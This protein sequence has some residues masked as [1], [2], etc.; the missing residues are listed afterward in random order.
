MLLNDSCWFPL[1][2]SKDWLTLAET[3]GLDYFGAASNYGIDAPEI[4]RF[5]RA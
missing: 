3:S 2:G 5:R 4:D 1:P